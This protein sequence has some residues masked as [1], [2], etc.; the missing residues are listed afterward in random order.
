MAARLPC[1]VLGASASNFLSCSDHDVIAYIEHVPSLWHLL[2][3]WEEEYCAEPG[4]VDSATHLLFALER[5][6]SGR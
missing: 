4:A 5:S 3:D 1:T 6:L 2:L